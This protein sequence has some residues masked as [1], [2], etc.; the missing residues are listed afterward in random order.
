[1]SSIPLPP[2]QQEIPVPVKA[3]SVK[4]DIRLWMI[5]FA[6]V[7]L[8]G[9]S[10]IVVSAT[11]VDGDNPHFAGGYGTIEKPYLISTPR[12]LDHLRQL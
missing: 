12:Q 1:M 8:I 9:I 10:V 2:A 7:L 3:Q 4:K 11:R 6:S 5:C